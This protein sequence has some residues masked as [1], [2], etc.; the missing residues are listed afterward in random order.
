MDRKCTKLMT[1]RVRK[2]FRRHGDVDLLA[3][4]QFGKWVSKIGGDQGRKRRTNIS[5]TNP[6]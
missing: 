4:P 2:A 3:V 1:L 6:L 5:I